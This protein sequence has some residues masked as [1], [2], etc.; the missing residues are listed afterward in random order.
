MAYKIVYGPE[1]F[2]PPPKKISTKRLQI[3][4]AA[5]FLLFLFSV[6]YFWATGTDRLRQYLIP[7]DLSVTEEAFLN[8]THHLRSGEPFKNSLETFCMEIIEHDL[9]PDY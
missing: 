5:F 9:L 3:L 6:K 4:T 7:S 1:P 8:L 2:Y